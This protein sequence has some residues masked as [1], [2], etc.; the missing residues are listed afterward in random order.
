[1]SLETVMA[2]F[3]ETPI[4]RLKPLAAAVGESADHVAAINT[5][6][7]SRVG[8]GDA[9]DLSRLSKT[10]REIAGMISQYGSLQERAPA[11]ESAGAGS[12]GSQSGVAMASDPSSLA[13]PGEIRSKRDVQVSLEQ[14]CGYFERN[15]PS[16]PI[17]L[18]LK[19]AQRLLPMNFIEIMKFL[20]A[21]AL[22]CLLRL[23]AEKDAK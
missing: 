21:D 16:S 18:L 5:I 8:E 13:V 3:R 1:M 17:P 7:A 19:G 23:S 14:I 11:G 2:A 22:K 15:E 12:A 20:D 6:L 4:Q 9:P 10:L